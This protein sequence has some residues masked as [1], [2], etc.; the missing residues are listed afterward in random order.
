MGTWD[1]R[2][3]R[4][5]V[6]ALIT[7]AL[8]RAAGSGSLAAMGRRGAE[9]LQDRNFAAFLLYLQT[10]RRIPA[11]CLAVEMEP[12]TTTVPP[13]EDTEPETEPV[14]ETEPAARFEMGPRRAFTPEEGE[15]VEI[16]YSGDYRADLGELIA[17][18][19]GLDFSGEEPRV[20]II[21][22]HATEAYAMEPGWE[23][24]PSAL[25]RTTD[26]DYNVIRVGREL[27]E[28]LRQGGV[29]V[30]QD[31]TLNDY[32]SYTG[33]YNQ[34]RSRIQDLLEEYPTIQ[35]VIDVHR[36]AVEDEA[37]NQLGTAREVLGQDSAQVMLV[38][39]T[40]E[41]GMDHPDW[42]ENLSWALKIQR[43]LDEEA[44]G[45][46]RPLN[47]RIERFNEDLTPGSCLLEVGTA[48]DT[49]QEALT[50]V[51]L[52]GQGLLQAMADLG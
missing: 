7:A 5:C 41:G 13:T 48:G 10:G 42:E 43:T 44:P 38:M 14:Q 12:E 18:P 21:S 24:T 32:P 15:S 50:A 45:L 31:T 23:Y 36:D 1:K 33:S 30:I 9:L 6:G 17:R 34:A 46:A 51:R 16:K 28:V 39:G 2:V 11:S 49:L 22:T 47:L 27:A 3:K 8:L 40:D 52:F 20:L 37:G 26:T 25:A 35:M 4:I 29:S 19:T